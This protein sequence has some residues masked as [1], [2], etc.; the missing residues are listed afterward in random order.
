MHRGL[1]LTPAPGSRDICYKMTEPCGCLCTYIMRSIYLSITDLLGDHPYLES[2]N[3]LGSHSHTPICHLESL[4]HT[5]CPSLS[6]LP[7]TSHRAAK[8]WLSPFRTAQPVP[9][10]ATCFT[11]PTPEKGR[12][13]GTFT[14]TKDKGGHGVR[15]AKQPEA[16]RALGW[17]PHRGLP[18]TSHS[19]SFFSVLE[20]PEGPSL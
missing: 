20:G 8:K 4:K 3:Y 13:R 12:H 19:L 14:C 1:G 6:D 5:S 2:P 11:L 9:P 7:S 10:Q 16:D 18:S 15:T 17:G